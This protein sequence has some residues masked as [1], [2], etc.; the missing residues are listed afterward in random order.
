VFQENQEHMDNDILPKVM[1]SDVSPTPRDLTLQIEKVGNLEVFHHTCFTNE[2]IYA[3]LIYDLPE[4]NEED[5][6]YVRLLSTL[7]AQMGCG[8]RNYQET[9]EYIQAHT[10]GTGASLALNVQAKDFNQFKPS[11]YIRG[12]ALHRKAHKLFPLIQQ[13]ASSNDFSDISRLKEVILK[14]YSGLQ[15]SLT[16]NSLRYATN[17]ATSQ[18]SVGS[19]INNAWYGL[20]YFLKMREIA[21]NFDTQVKFLVKK[22]QEL[23]ENLLCLDNPR[24]VI[25]CDAS[26]YEKLKTHGFYGL[27]DLPTKSFKPWIGKYLLPTVPSQGRTVASPVA[28]ISK[29]LSTVPYAHPDAPA[30]NLAPFLFDN[31]VLHTRLREQGGAYGG[32]AVCNSMMGNFYFYSYR[33]PNIYSTLQAFKDSVKTIVEGRFN[34]SDLEEAKL[35]MIQYLDSPIPPGSRGDRAYGWLCEGK[36]FELR[37]AFRSKLLSLTREEIIETVKKHILPKI[38]SGTTVVF[39]GRELLEKENTHLIKNGMP[40][41]KIESI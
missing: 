21:T 20:D 13:L 3:D 7:I 37:Q 27:K 38:D 36:T 4:I 41:L 24:L 29:V 10:G 25:T 16:Q 19:K 8:K 28:F 22:L 23:Q 33:D 2:I 30:L 15:S 40:P 5:L 32:G 11:L 1:L 34:E 17:L 26:M 12:K 18:L 14:H 9:L 31:L 6:P 39:S 35:E